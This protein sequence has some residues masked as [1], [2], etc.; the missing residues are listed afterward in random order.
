MRDEDGNVMQEEPDE[1]EEEVDLKNLV[2]YVVSINYVS[3][4]IIVYLI[5]LLFLHVSPARFWGVPG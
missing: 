1:E 3:Y 4:S 2:C 5:L